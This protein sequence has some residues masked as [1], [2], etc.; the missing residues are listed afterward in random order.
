MG[1]KQESLHGP[2]PRAS[3][4]LPTHFF[5]PAL[6]FPVTGVEPGSCGILSKGQKVIPPLLVD[7]AQLQ[8]QGCDVLGREYAFRFPKYEL[9]S[10]DRLIVGPDLQIRLRQRFMDV[11]DV[12]ADPHCLFETVHSFL[13]SMLQKKRLPSKVF[14]SSKIF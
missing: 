1:N 3:E 5:R 13:I 7:L 2:K 12:L 9:E 6:R 4:I 8:M 14:Q 11:L 10:G